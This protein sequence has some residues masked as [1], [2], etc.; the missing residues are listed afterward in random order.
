MWSFVGGE[1]AV[2]SSTATR[3]TGGG[4]GVGCR[5]V[6]LAGPGWGP[7]AGSPRTEGAQGLILAWPSP[8]YTITNTPGEIFH[9][10]NMFA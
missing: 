1:G 6:S 9:L 4:S 7:T 10:K 2:T 5:G 3:V 8:F